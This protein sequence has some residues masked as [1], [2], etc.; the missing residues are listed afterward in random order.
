MG[1]EN[2]VDSGEDYESYYEQLQYLADLLRAQS[3]RDTSEQRSSESEEEFG[4]PVGR[5]DSVHSNMTD[6]DIEAEIA[7][8]LSVTQNRKKQRNVIG[9]SNIVRLISEGNIFGRYE[10]NVKRRILSNFLP[11]NPSRVAQYRHKVFCGRYCGE[12]GERFMT[13]S[14]DCRIRIYNTQR[15]QFSS[16]QEIEVG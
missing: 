11:S 5:L 7:K 10:E 3:L 8:N 2:T 14:Q 9:S 12:A 4:S 6:T 15:G 13:A 16:E 1:D